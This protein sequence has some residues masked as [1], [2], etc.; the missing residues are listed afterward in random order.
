MYYGGPAPPSASPASQPEP[1]WAYMSLN[2]ALADSDMGTDS[3]TESS[4]WNEDNA[5]EDIPAPPAD[6]TPEQLEAHLYWAYQ[7]TKS[8]WR[9]HTGKP[10]RRF[11]RV[12]RRIGKFKGGGKGKGKGFGKGFRRGKGAHFTFLTE[13]QVSE[14]V[15][16]FGKARGKGKGRKGKSSGSGFGRAPGSKNPTG[17]DGE[18]MKCYDCGSDEHLAG[19]PDCPNRGKGKGKNKGKM[20][21]IMPSTPR[22][23][24]GDSGEY[25]WH[26]PSHWQSPSASG[27]PLATVHHTWPI[28]QAD[29]STGHDD[30]MPP[31]DHAPPAAAD[32]WQAN[33]PWSRAARGERTINQDDEIDLLRRSLNETQRL[34]SDAVQGQ[35]E[36]EQTFRAEVAHEWQHEVSRVNQNA[37]YR[38]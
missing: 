6:A 38:W 26:S 14:E 33:D 4:D 20:F 11:R 25:D 24:Q 16:A 21:P 31:A 36:F 8:Q 2:D 35:Q 5:D 22:G 23:P 37:N 27:G 10:V 28:L 19:S 9:R 32:P 7:K 29:G 17:R 15:Y 18:I 30:P 3:D 12:I 13:T 34:A 1:Q